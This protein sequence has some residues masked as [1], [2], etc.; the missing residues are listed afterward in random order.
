MPSRQAEWQRKM[1]A[2]NRCQVCGQEAYVEAY[3][4]K[5]HE[6]RVEK[7]RVKSEA[8]GTKKQCSYC[9]VVGHNKRGCPT[10]KLDEAKKAR[11]RK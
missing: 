11:K 2:T 7:L 4:Q 8:Q 9:H 10:R 6:L 3:C 1:R 5:H